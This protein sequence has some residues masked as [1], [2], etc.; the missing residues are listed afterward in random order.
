M[1]YMRHWQLHH[2]SYASVTKCALLICA[3][4][5]LGLKQRIK[6]N[7]VHIIQLYEDHPDWTKPAVLRESHTDTSHKAA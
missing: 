1:C 7:N 2:F 4:I 5:F 6:W 3:M